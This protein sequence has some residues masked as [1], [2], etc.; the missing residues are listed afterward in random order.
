MEI[1]IAQAPNHYTQTILYQKLKSKSKSG[2]GLLEKVDTLIEC[3]TPLLDNIGKGEFEDYTLH[4]RVHS[5]KLLHLSEYIISPET[6]EQLSNLEIAILIMAFYLHDLGMF[7]TT[8][9]RLSILKSDAFQINLANYKSIESRMIEIEESLKKELTEG[10]KSIYY[11]ELFQLQEVALTEFLRKKHAKQETYFQKIEFIKT[12]TRRSDL[13]EF[14]GISFLNEL[15]EICI[16]HNE[17]SSYLLITEGL[18]REKF[19]RDSYISGLRVNSQF[20]AAVLR[21]VDI[22]DFDRERTPYSLF[23]AIAIDRKRLPGFEISLK[24]WNKHLAIHTIAIND[25]EIQII[26]SANNPNIEKAINEFCEV[27]QIELRNT[28]A[29][30][31]R[32]IQSIVETY[33]VKIPQFVRPV[34]TS[35]GYV[36]KDF[37]IK[38]SQNSIINLLMGESLYKNRN[39]AIREL[40]QNSIDACNAKSKIDASYNPEINV[41]IEEDHEKTWL[42]ISDNGIGMDEHMI[43]NYLL[44]VGQSYYKFRRIQKTNIIIGERVFIHLAVWHRFFVSFYYRRCY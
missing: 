35:N 3:V 15:I 38:L 21:I 16:S 18:F 25:F 30:I 23:E 10:E 17:D 34:I 9:E 6:I 19:K 39:V 4:N 12:H 31:N 22:L 29:I 1:V 27:I 33:K 42:I 20:C 14:K 24:E 8:E 40:I 36:Y 7:I 41:S 26:G 13:F 11:L 2:E 5:L 28:I 44:T 32:N 37:S 43:S